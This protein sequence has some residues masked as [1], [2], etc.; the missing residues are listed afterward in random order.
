MF[1]REKAT[2]DERRH[3][4]WDAS[5]CLFSRAFLN[6]AW[7]AANAVSRSGGR[8]GEDSM[9]MARQ[10]RDRGLTGLRIRFEVTDRIA[11]RV[12]GDRP[13]DWLQEVAPDSGILH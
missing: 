5:T 2:G 1:C 8:V 9:A 7:W 10:K 12:L 11:A 4:V 6:T 13:G 3:E